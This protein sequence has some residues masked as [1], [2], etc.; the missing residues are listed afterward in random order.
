MSK[1]GILMAVVWTAL[2]GAAELGAEEAGGEK[3]LRTVVVTATR[4]EQPIES[5]NSSVSVV[6]AED[7]SDRQVTTLPEAL[8]GVA[9]VD[10][11]QSG[12]MGTNSSI[13]IRGAEADQSLFLVDGVEVNSATLGGFNL[14]N[15]F[16]ENVDRVEILRGPGGALYGSE[17]I[18]GVVQVMTRKGEGPLHGTVSAGGGNTDTSANLAEVSGE[19]GIVAYTAS[20]GY[21]TTAGYQR[22]N[23][24]FSNLTSSARVDVTPIDGGTL[25][26]FFR[27]A[28][29]SLG[30]A[31]NNIGAGYGDFIDPNARQKDEFYLGKGEWE[32]SPIE[33]LQYRVSGAYARTLNRFR[34]EIDPDVLDSPNYWGDA[35][36]LSSLRVPS[37]IKTGEAQVNYSEGAIGLTTVGFDFKEQSGEY[38]SVM[39]DATETRYD[40]SRWNCAGYAQQ[41][42]HLFD[43]RLR[44]VGG[45]RADGNEDFG[46]EVS[47]SWSAGYFVDW[48][49]RPEWATHLRGG[50]AEGFKAPTFNALYYPMFGNKNLDAETSSEYDGGLVQR[51][52]V[53]W[54]SVEATYFDRRTSHMIQYVSV[55]SCPNAD[56]E[57]GTYFTPCDIG[58]AD[59]RGVETALVVGPLAGLSMRGSY[60]YLDWDLSS[61]GALLRRPHNRM[62]SFV[63]YERR[64][65]FLARDRLS[66]NVQ[67]LFTGE[68][69]D[70]DPLT[71]QPV[72]HQPMFVRVD[73]AAGYDIPRRTGGTIG[74]FARVQNLFDRDYQE[75]RGFQS[76]PINVLAGLRLGF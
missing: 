52:G 47:A 38:K 13:F 22:D 58:R 66:A 68:R 67:V 74:V 26:G 49:G 63:S 15:I 45:L 75:V 37:D 46:T 31:N 30:L 29:S 34:D 19:K 65:A 1:A 33:N 61:G 21:L 73:A 64:E 71:Y 12:S 41:Q 10:V 51:L 50:Y 8:R 56:V 27:S 72:D 16:P 25:R 44:L 53:T 39:G 57:P 28:N 24:D 40:H 43:D 59:V 6:S 5:V 32:H 23:D 48:W 60:M 36:F 76:P 3:P 54:L 11:S 42:L 35:F 62:S 9:G 18:G 14:G 20:L 2:Q 55:D 4:T 70:I 7:I 17:A 69:H